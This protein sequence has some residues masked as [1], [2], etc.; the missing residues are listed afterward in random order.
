VEIQKTC[1]LRKEKG[2]VLRGRKRN[3][4]LM[5]TSPNALSNLK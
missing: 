2:K 3:L 4:T 5:G 1:Y